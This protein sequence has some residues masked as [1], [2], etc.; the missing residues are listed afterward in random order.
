MYLIVRKSPTINNNIQTNAI[1]SKTVEILNHDI[2]PRNIP[3][4]IIKK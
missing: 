1:G 4:M 2:I 3:T